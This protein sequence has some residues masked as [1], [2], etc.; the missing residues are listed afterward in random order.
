MVLR[1]FEYVCLGLLCLF[2]GS[3]FCVFGIWL[4]V[5]LVLGL[6]FCNFDLFELCG[7]ECVVFGSLSLYLR[8]DDLSYKLFKMACGYFSWFATGLVCY[9]CGFLRFGIV[10]IVC[11][12][13]VICNL[14]V[15]FGCVCV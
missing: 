8:V 5:V 15:C 9:L 3:W 13:N 11:I 1:W 10:L 14:G 2:D 7:F 4:L 6:V 12:G